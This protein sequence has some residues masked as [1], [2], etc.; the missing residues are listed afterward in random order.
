M[1]KQI[2][3]FNLK[4]IR[5]CSWENNGTVTNALYRY[6]DNWTLLRLFLS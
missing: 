1:V 6:F 2:E 3:D 4:W 5:L